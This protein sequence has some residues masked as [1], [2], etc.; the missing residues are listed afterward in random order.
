MLQPCGHCRLVAIGKLGN[1]R[2]PYARQPYA[3][4]LGKSGPD[5]TLPLQ[6]KAAGVEYY[7]PAITANPAGR[8]IP[9]TG[10]RC[11]RLAKAI[12]FWQQV[13]WDAAG[14]G[15]PAMCSMGMAA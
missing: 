5:G 2:A 13:E 8:P 6:W 7:N 10:Y 11:A 1:C 15:R 12:P 3:V 9:E 4:W 14:R